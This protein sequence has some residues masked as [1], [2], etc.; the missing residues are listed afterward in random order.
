MDIKD[1]VDGKICVILYDS[2][3]N[4]WLSELVRWGDREHGQK[5]LTNTMPASTN[6]FVMAS[7]SGGSD[8]NW[9][10]SIYY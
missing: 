3:R 9:G 5:V 7:Q 1:T 2:R 8:T 6:F 10:G 4:D